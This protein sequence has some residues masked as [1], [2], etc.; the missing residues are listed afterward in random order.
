MSKNLSE[1]VIAF[2][3]ANVKNTVKDAISAIYLTEKILFRKPQHPPESH[4]AI[5]SC[6]LTPYVATVKEGYRRRGRN[7]MR[8]IIL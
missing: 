1:N 3:F 6:V 5:V 7:R 4:H 8:R 2:G